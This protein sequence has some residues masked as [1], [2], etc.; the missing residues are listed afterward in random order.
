[1]AEPDSLAELLT[2][3]FAR[4]QASHE[5]ARAQAGPSLFGSDRAVDHWTFDYA[6]RAID[7]ALGDA[8]VL[9][10][11]QP[12][13][14]AEPALRQFVVDVVATL[15][16]DAQAPP[17]NEFGLRPAPAAL[18]GVRRHGQVQ[19][20]AALASLASRHVDPRLKPARRPGVGRDKW[21][22]IGVVIVVLLAVLASI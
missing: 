2:A 12:Q 8:V 3:R 17:A 4:F 10:L 19:L 15:E 7:E 11:Q 20:G 1:V 22:L 16:A 9:L 18:D 5:R 21:L 14:D 6:K 13:P